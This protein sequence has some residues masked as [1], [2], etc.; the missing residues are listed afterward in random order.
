MEIHF[1]SSL[2]SDDE[3]K[4]A[5][6]VLAAATSLLDHSSIA[7]SLR[8]ETSGGEVLQRSSP[9]AIAATPAPPAAAAVAAT[10]PAPATPELPQEAEALAKLDLPSQ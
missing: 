10:T 1:I 6:A 9:T 3:A 2:T 8:I 5:A 4:V 7:Y